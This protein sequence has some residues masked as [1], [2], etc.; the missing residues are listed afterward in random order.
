MDTFSHALWGKGLFGYR[1]YR[2][3]AL[4][5]GAIPDLLS[6]GIYFLF[7]IF[8][9]LSNM[10]FGKPSIEEIPIWVFNLYDFSHSMIVAFIFI[11]IA[12][13]HSKI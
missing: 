12:Y 13:W 5:F 9:N 6:F 8:S 1:K 11:A 3:Y 7:N 10:K 2:W 4:L